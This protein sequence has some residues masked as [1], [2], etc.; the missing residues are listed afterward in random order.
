MQTKTTLPYDKIS[1]ATAPYMSSTEVE[2]L[3]EKYGQAQVILEYG[4]GGSTRIAAQMPGKL[5]YSVESDQKWALDLQREIDASNPQ[6]AITLYPVDI[7]QVGPWGRPVDD[8]KWR[9]YHRYPMAIWDERFFRHPDLV[10]IDGR[11]RCACFVTTMMRITRPVTVL[12][13]DYGARPMYRR[14][15]Q[16]IEPTRVINT[17]AHFELVPDMI[18]KSD[19]SFVMEQF[20]LISLLD[21]R[22]ETFYALDDPLS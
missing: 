10:L 20:S 19:W 4:S 3:T 14:L 17:M 8:S 1:D 21:G 12:F 11:M 15:E 16:L 6:S 18:Q 9:S 22:G 7:G 13:D 2:Y 5:V